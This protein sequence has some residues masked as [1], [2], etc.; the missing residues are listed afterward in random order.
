MLHYKISPTG[1]DYNNN[2]LTTLKYFTEERLANK[3]KSKDTGDRYYKD[4]EQA[5]KVVINSAYGFMGASGLN[6]NYPK[7]AADTTRYG[8]EIITKSVDWAEAKGYKISNCDTDSISFTTGTDLTDQNR[9]DIL[10]ELNAL[11]PS[12]IRFENDG[13]YKCLLVLKA[14]NYVMYDGKKMKLKGSSIRDQ[15]KEKALS[16]MLITMLQTIIDDRLAELPSIY[17]KYI[18]EAKHPTDIKR[19]AQK[20]TVTKSVLNC[21]GDEESRKNERDVWDAIASKSLQEGD[22]VYV[23]PAILSQTVETKEYKNGKV[24][25]KITVNTGLRTVDDW[26]G[27]HSVDKLVK[28]VVDTTEILANVID[29]ELFVDYTKSKNKELLESV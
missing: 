5:Q 2:F 24:K 21:S 29:T 20:K 4:M 7:G 12:M 18:K 15:K 27:D 19:W 1:K 28:R 23:Y 14:K 13:Y 22:K 10:K 11:Y 3:K 17:L 16:E 26:S 9:L 25:E 6:Y 8:R